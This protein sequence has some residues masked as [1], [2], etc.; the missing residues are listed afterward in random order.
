MRSG[1]DKCW[2]LGVGIQIQIT[3][4]C[5]FIPTYSYRPYTLADTVVWEKSPVDRGNKI[6]CLNRVNRDMERVPLQP[7][8]WILRKMPM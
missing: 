1:E 7:P 5:Q 6:L 2:W 4:T 8:T 3:L